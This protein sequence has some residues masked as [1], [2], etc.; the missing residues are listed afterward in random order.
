MILEEVDSESGS[1]HK[2]AT[3]RLLSAACDWA[4]GFRNQ[5]RCNYGGWRC[6]VWCSSGN[7]I[8]STSCSIYSDHSHCSCFLPSRPIQH[9]HPDPLTLPPRPLLQQVQPPQQ[10]Q[11]QRLWP[12][13]VAADVAATGAATAAVRTAEPAATEDGAAAA[14]SPPAISSIGRP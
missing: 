6:S 10:W 2:M 3:Q 7:G 11:P 9:L 14:A 12:H 5:I 4:L 13:A 8:S 1:S